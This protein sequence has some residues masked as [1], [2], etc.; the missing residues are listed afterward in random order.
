MAQD[1]TRGGSP[2][3]P[4]FNRAAKAGG[5][6]THLSFSGRVAEVLR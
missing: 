4:N 6:S 5:A 1:R 2:S 3:R